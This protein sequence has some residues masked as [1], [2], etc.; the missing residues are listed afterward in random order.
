MTT[1]QIV[2]ILFR[3]FQDGYLLAI[4]STDLYSLDISLLSKL[5][6]RAF[7][8]SHKQIRGALERDNFKNEKVHGEF[9]DEELYFFLTKKGGETW[10]YLFKP[11][12]NQYFRRSILDWEFISENIQNNSI[13]SNGSIICCAD[14]KFGEKIIAIEHLLNCEQLIVYPIE[15]S[16]MWE[17]FSPWH[18]VYWKTL[19]CG[20]VVS[21]QALLVEVDKNAENITELKE[22]TEEVYKAREWYMDTVNWYANRL[23]IANNFKP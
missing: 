17:K 12:W 15:E 2:D 19:A 13:P 22:L 6:T 9:H 23:N 20:Y 7:I 8:P 4:T 16:I 14:Q 10:E 5:L 21:Y 11:K 3:L 1:N 18:P